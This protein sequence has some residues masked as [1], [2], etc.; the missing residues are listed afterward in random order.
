MDDVLSD[1][2]PVPQARWKI[3][4][5]LLVCLGLLAVALAL[6]Q[7]TKL[8]PR[9]SFYM[10]LIFILAGPGALIYLAQLIRPGRLEISPRG[11]VERGLFRTRTWTWTSSVFQKIQHGSCTR[12]SSRKCQT[13]SPPL[14]LRTRS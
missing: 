11:L 1:I 6:F 4:L 13:G 3:G 9:L 7:E 14:A 10:W 8:G 5:R 2:T 12:I